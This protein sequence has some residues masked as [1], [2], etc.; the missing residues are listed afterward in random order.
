[1]PSVDLKSYRG[2]EVT[3]CYDISGHGATLR[4]LSNLGSN[5]GDY[6]NGKQDESASASHAETPGESVRENVGRPDAKVMQ[7]LVLQS[8]QF[9]QLFC[10]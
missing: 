7:K 9:V 5:L 6:A 8:H 10:A 1:M 4:S 2:Q 3:I